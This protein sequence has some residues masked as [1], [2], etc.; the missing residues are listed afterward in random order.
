LAGIWR[1]RRIAIDTTLHLRAVGLRRVLD[2]LL[3]EAL[4]LAFAVVAFAVSFLVPLSAR[5]SAIRVVA[6]VPDGC[7]RQAS[8]GLSWREL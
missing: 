2:F 6:S 5:A 4:C 3:I 1:H 8:G 7:F